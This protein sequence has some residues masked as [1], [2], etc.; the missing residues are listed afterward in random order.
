MFSKPKKKIDPKIR[1]QHTSFTKRVKEAS[2]YKREARNIPESSFGKMLASFGLDTWPRRV[3]VLAILGLIVYFVYIPNIFFVDTAEIEG[4]AT[5]NVGHVQQTIDSY[6]NKMKVFPQRHL[7]F[8]NVEALRAQLLTDPH[9]LSVE[10]IEKKYPNGLK[11]IVQP[12][13]EFLTLETPEHAYVFF[14]DGTVSRS[15]NRG[16]AGTFEVQGA[17]L[18]MQS[19]QLLLLGKKYLSN[20]FIQ[21]LQTERKFFPLKVGYEIDRF[22][23]REPPP[24]KVEVTEGETVPATE[25]GITISED[26]PLD[27]LEFYLVAKQAK[28]ENPYTFKIL[29]DV[30]TDLEARN[31]KISLLLQQFPEERRAQIEY[32]DMRFDNKG[33]VCFKN[34]SCVDAGEPEPVLTPVEPVTEPQKEQ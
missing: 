11:V 5:G 8:L 10:R 12:K 7:L 1:F 34:T 23:L 20:R 16:L 18:K 17:L 13:V 9:V 31:E 6:L 28:T 19:D 22:E 15:L 3:S 26:K 30:K 25:P 27:P 21:A 24:K 4:V 32:L 14:N 29:L 2:K 33:Y